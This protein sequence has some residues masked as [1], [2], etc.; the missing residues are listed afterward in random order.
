MADVKIPYSEPG[1]A[2]FQQLDSYLQGFLLSGS[3]PKLEPGFPMEIAVGQ[4]LQQFQ[5][6]GLSGGKLVPAVLGTTAAMCVCTQ[7]VAAPTG[8]GVKV[9]IW[10]A[11]CFNPD[12]LVWDATYN[13]DD[14]KA[15]AFMGAPSPTRILIRKRG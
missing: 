7:A 11:G 6:L 15:N 12:A 3:D 1:L 5:V 10:F 14:K 13:T 4:A 8:A 9:P 2:A